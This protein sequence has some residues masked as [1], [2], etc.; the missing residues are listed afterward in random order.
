M[1]K[2]VASD[3][4]NSRS[5]FLSSRLMIFG[6]VELRF[7][8]SSRAEIC[9]IFVRNSGYGLEF[10]MVVSARFSRDLLPSIGEKYDWR[11]H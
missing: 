5:S 9:R 10:L 1:A 8:S 7:S 2:L 3:V 11:V 4:R 6:G